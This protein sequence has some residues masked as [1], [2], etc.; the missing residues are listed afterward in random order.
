MSDFQYLPRPK[1]TTVWISTRSLEGWKPLTTGCSTVD[2]TTLIAYISLMPWPIIKP[3]HSM[4]VKTLRIFLVY[5]KSSYWLYYPI[6]GMQMFLTRF[7][8]KWFL[9]AHTESKKI[10]FEL[11]QIWDNIYYTNTP[12][13]Y[14]KCGLRFALAQSIK[15]FWF[16]VG[17]LGTQKPFLG[18]PCQ[19]QFHT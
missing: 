9:C 10:C 13:F 17:P 6:L 16:C 12:H 1:R 18:E 19:K 2:Q 5:D 14:S 8:Q 4:K 3:F 7:S 11:D 15:Y